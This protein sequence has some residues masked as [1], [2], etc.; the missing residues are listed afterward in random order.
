MKPKSIILAL[1][2]TVFCMPV[3]AQDFRAD[4]RALLAKDDMQ[5]TLNLLYKWQ[6]ASPNDPELY[7]AFFN[8]YAKEGLKEIVNL[9]KDAPTAQAFELKDKNGKTAGYLGGSGMHNEAYLKKGFMYIDTGINKFPERLDLRFG[10]IF[11]LGKLEEH[12]KFTQEIVKT[13]DYGESIGL[14]WLW[15]DNKPVDGPEKMMLSN[16]QSYVV[17]LYNAGDKNV[18]YMKTIAETILKYHP[19]HVESLTNLAIAFIISNQFSEAIPPLLKAEHVNPQ[20]YI[21]LNNIAFCYSK[22]GDKSNA[23]KYYELTLRYGDEQ[24]KK[25]ATEKLRELKKS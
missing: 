9:S 23:I 20:D 19:Q 14:K 8:L 25:Q 4:F 7:S 21:V 17:Q 6:A 5:T 12:E 1:L 18:G 2:L 16:I 13:V 24:I 11:I 3:F 15:T 10:K 22:I